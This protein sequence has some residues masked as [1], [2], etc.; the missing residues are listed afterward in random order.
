LRDL[1][2]VRAAGRPD[3]VG[4]TT[5]YYDSGTR[6]IEYLYVENGGG[7][8]RGYVEPGEAAIVF[9]ATTYVAGG[10][11]MTL[12]VR[13]TLMADGY[14][15]WSEAQDKGAWATMFKVRMLKSS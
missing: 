4:E 5:Y 1:H 12:R 15:A 13:W 9:P 3:Y 6:R 14:E 8:M 10:Q 2:T 11:A 7:V